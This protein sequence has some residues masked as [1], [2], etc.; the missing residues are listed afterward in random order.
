MQGKILDYNNEFKSGLIRGNDGNK[1]RFS[2]DDCKSDL[3]PRANAEVD[4]EVNGDKAVEIY[5]LTKDAIDDIKDIASSAANTTVTAAKA[6]TNTIKKFIPILIIIAIL[7]GIVIFISE[8]VIPQQ[9]ENERQI[10]LK[11]LKAIVSEANTLFKNH[12]YQ[13]A[14]SK[15]ESAK[16]M[17][18]AYYDTWKYDHKI[19]ECYLAM[20]KPQK[21]LSLMGNPPNSKDLGY[22]NNPLEYGVQTEQNANSCILASKIYKQIG[23]HQIA[24]MY[25]DWA[26]KAGDCSLV[27]K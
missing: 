14:I 27:E 20:N 19:A 4:F 23:D 2:I 16:L 5:I 8:V 22:A 3:K 6:T 7:G 15:Y 18:P 1:Y 12:D 13:D 17:D 10:E 24:K 25:A 11:K 26:C 9:K 21:A